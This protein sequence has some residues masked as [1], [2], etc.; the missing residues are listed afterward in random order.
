MAD[1]TCSFFRHQGT[2]RGVNFSIAGDDNFKG[3]VQAFQLEFARVLNRVYDL[4]SNGFYYIEGP[5]KGTVFF[6]KVVGPLGAP[7]LICT[8]NPSTLTLDAS[9]M[10]CSTSSSPSSSGLTYHLEYALPER[11]QG[12]GSSENMIIMFG[13]GYTFSGLY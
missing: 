9:N 6:N 13:V 7:K 2:I 5:S 1:S 4:S 10:L 11:L 12:Q 8:C 3:L